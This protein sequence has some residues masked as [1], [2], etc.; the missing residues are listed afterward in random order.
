MLDQLEALDAKFQEVEAQ[1]QEPAIVSDPRKL[2]EL[3][4]LRSELEP[5]VLAWAQQRNLLKQLEE[6]E[7]ILADKT[8]DLELRE[9]AELEIPEPQAGHRSGSSG[10]QAACSSPRTPR[11]PAT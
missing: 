8:M 6:A 5:V 2:R 7:G 11:M 10:D 4:K 1:L 3:S 9:M